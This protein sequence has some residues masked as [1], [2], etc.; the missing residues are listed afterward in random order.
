MISSC[1]IWNG[2]TLPLPDADIQPPSTWRGT[3][4]TCLRLEH[5]TQ[6]VESCPSEWTDR[7]EREREKWCIGCYLSL[8]LL[9]PDAQ[10]GYMGRGRP[11][12]NRSCNV[13]AKH[14]M[15]VHSSTKR[16]QAMESSNEWLLMLLLSWMKKGTQLNKDFSITLL[17]EVDQVFFLFSSPPSIR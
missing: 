12:S 16:V 1:S 14:H 2:I 8:S 15:N 3:Y 17:P 6:H 4:S 11:L 10:N 13:N 5:I 9:F 7:I